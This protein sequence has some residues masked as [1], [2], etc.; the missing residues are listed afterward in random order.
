MD[1]IV[2]KLAS[3]CSDL[4]KADPGPAGRARVAELL[5]EV[6]SNP[7]N[8]D[9]LIP[10][11]AGER[12]VLYK[13]PDLGFCILAHQYNAAKKSS[14]HDH[15]GSWAIVT[16]V[17]GCELH[18]TYQLDSASTGDNLVLS[19]GPDIDVRPGQSIA[20]MPDDIHS[21]HTN[22]AAPLFHLHLYGLGFE[23]QGQ[24]RV[25]DLTNNTCRRF[26][27]DDVGFIEDWR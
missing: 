16:A 9:A 26:K 6:I 20:M 13:D 3:D 8:V 25:Y 7:E 1:D 18:R 19:R 17:Q 15:G 2:A 27:L 10:P 14:P 11:T 12:D 23:F 4:L 21:I 22:T 24:R 5:S